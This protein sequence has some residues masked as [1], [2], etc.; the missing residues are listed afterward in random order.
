MIRKAVK[1]G[2]DS[3][4]ITNGQIQYN[5]YEAQEEK[6]KQGLKK[7]YDTFVYDQLNKIAKN[8]GVK[9]ERIDI[10]EGEAPKEIQ[11]SPFNSITVRAPKTFVFF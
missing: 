2:R 10:S 8:Y 7:F 11:D 1:D 4:A 6:N 5:R 9:L 3:I